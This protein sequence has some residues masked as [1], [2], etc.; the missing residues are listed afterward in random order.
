[1][2]IVFF[3]KALLAFALLFS[4]VSAYSQTLYL[5][6]GALKTCSSMAPRNCTPNAQFPDIAKTH[7]NFIVTKKAMK[8]IAALWPSNSQKRFN[9]TMRLL[10]R[11]PKDK[12][13]T[14]SQLIKAINQHDSELYHQWSNR[15]YYFIFDMLELPLMVNGKRV[16]E[17]VLTKYNSEPASSDI[18]QQIATQVAKTPSQSLYLL[19]ASSRDPYESADFYQGLF[20]AYGIKAQWLPLTPA[21]AQAVSNQDCENLDHYRTSINQVFNRDYVYPDLTTKEYNLCMAGVEGVK[22]ALQSVDAVMLNGGDQSLT[23][24]VFYHNQSDAELPWTDMVRNKAVLIGTS[25]GTAVQSGGE[26]QYGRVPMITNG[27]SIEALLQGAKNAPAPAANCDQHGGCEDLSADT[28]TY[29]DQGGLGSFNH[30]ILDTH[31]SERGRTFRLAV[32]TQHSKQ[33][34]G[35]GVDETT[36]LVVDTRKQQ[37]QVIGKAGVVVTKVLGQNQFS[38]SFYPGGSEFTMA[39]L[40]EQQHQTEAQANDTRRTEVVEN[41]V[42]EERMRA[43]AQRLCDNGNLQVIASSDDLPRITIGRSAKTTC[44]KQPSGQYVVK[45]MQISW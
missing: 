39:Q 16:A 6:G 21:L 26:N 17:L 43:T 10:R 8:E 2:N 36:A 35:F 23:R 31:F 24:Q 13:F 18:I 27:S 15:E 20:K 32:L 28:L 37:M 7:A 4:S 30:G 11:I 19:T 41:L 42:E 29:H 9:R 33:K 40:I 12:I 38:Y 44:I 34:F 3:V 14:R 5:I 22:K 1:M 45:D 25:A